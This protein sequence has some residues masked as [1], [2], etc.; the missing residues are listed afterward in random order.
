VQISR[1]VRSRLFIRVG[2]EVEVPKRYLSKTS[3]SEIAKF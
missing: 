3:D 1:S 2:A